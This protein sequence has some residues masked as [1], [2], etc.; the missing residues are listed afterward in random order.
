MPATCG[1][2]RL[3]RTR[4]TILTT[5]RRPMPN[6]V[7]R[8]YV[9]ARWMIRATLFLLHRHAATNVRGNRTQ[10]K[11]P[12]HLLDTPPTGPSISVLVHKARNNDR[13]AMRHRLCRNATS[14][15]RA[16]LCHQTPLD[17]P[18]WHLPFLMESRRCHQ[19]LPP[20]FLRN[21]AFR[22]KRR[23]THQQLDQDRELELQKAPWVGSRIAG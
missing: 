18:R 23:R 20:V 2:R 4:S 15:I 3:P 10:L 11:A 9:P 17:L 16:C 6:V 12:N 19:D 14:A 21:P 22:P 8:R 1:T 7:Q 13:L 5:S